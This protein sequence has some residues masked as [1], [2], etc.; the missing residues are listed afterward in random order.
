MKK[1]ISQKLK[2]SRIFSILIIL[3]G[4]LLMVYMIKAEDEPGALP[5]LLIILGTTWFVLILVRK[6]KRK[7]QNLEL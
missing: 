6:K 1:E 4:V 7:H 3:I 5:L 2:L